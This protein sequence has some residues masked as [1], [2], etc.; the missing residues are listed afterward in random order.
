GVAPAR[1]PS[2]AGRGGLR[3][4]GHPGGPGPLPAGRAPPPA[5]VFLPHVD[6]G[7]VL[8]GR[9]RTPV[10]LDRAHSQAPA[11][12]RDHDGRGARPAAR[13]R[14]VRR[15]ST[16]GL[17]YGFWG[18]LSIGATFESV[19]RRPTKPGRQGIR[20]HHAALVATERVVNAHATAW[21]AKA[22]TPV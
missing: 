6:A 16:L 18:L 4:R 2:R 8:Q 12:A 3:A 1:H 17:R 11:I 22:A 10:R 9:R 14:P 19:R 7:R 5:L 13:P 21:R 20:T 15:E